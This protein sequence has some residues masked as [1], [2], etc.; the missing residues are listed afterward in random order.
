MARVGISLG[1]NLGDRASNLRS[2]VEGLEPIRSSPHLLLSPVFETDPVDCPPGSGP[3]LNAVVEIETGLSPLALLEATQDLERN[4][5]RPG[6]REVNA[7]RTI[8]LDL[9]YYDDLVLEAPGLIL[10]HP[11]MFERAFV[12]KPLASIRPDL[13]PVD[14]LG[15]T[16]DTGVHVTRFSLVP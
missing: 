8:D 10:P 14:K 2:A 12:L 9:L 5:G 1:S 7:P 16:T 13:V 4:L 15:K 11:R 6:V 3:F